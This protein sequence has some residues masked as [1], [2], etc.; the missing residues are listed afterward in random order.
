MIPDD[1]AKSK[2][3]ISKAVSPYFIKTSLGKFYLFVKKCGD[4]SEKN[5]PAIALNAAPAISMMPIFFNT[6]P[7]MTN[8]IEGIA[9][10]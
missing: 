10:K 3:K 1:I 2:Y 8:P 4:K 7:A 5:A 9:P 6:S